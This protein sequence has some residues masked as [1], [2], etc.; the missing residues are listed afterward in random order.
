LMGRGGSEREGILCIYFSLEDWSDV[1]GST[2]DSS[3]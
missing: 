2:T 1:S 3:L